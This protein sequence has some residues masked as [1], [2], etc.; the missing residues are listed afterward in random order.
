MPSS[1]Q[2]VSVFGSVADVTERLSS[3]KFSGVTV[4]SPMEIIL[5]GGVGLELDAGSEEMLARDLCFLSV[6]SDLN[7]TSLSDMLSA[8]SLDRA[9]LS[10]R[11]ASEDD[12]TAPA[13]TAP[14]PADDPLAA[15]AEEMTVGD[16]SDSLSRL[17]DTVGRI[18]NFTAL[19][20][21]DN[22]PGS[23][24][25][26]AT[27]LYADSPLGRMMPEGTA[28][29]FV[30]CQLAVMTDTEQGPRIGHDP[31]SPVVITGL[32]RKINVDE[33][34]ESLMVD[35]DGDHLFVS[36]RSLSYIIES[37]TPSIITLMVPLDEET[38]QVRTWYV[39]T[40]SI[41]GM[42]PEV[43]RASMA[44]VEAEVNS[45]HINVT[46]AWPPDLSMDPL[47]VSPALFDTEDSAQLARILMT[48]PS[49]DDEDD[50]EG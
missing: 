35:P 3:P 23:N 27:V 2:I 38:V 5:T 26:L 30:F 1:K 4:H 34:E 8:A 32:V 42:S 21:E 10:V 50:D 28:S 18:K 17:Q 11:L 46:Y 37:G 22:S 40:D 29:G 49:D 31:A 45:D 15:L 39:Y 13:E 16:L 33:Q 9:P 44:T 25:N 14:A 6:A 12:A 7:E 41:D 36:D 43:A 48:L 20:P 19:L 47:H 24:P